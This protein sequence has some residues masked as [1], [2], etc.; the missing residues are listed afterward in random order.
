ML[1]AAVIVV[2]GIWSAARL[3]LDVTPDISNLQVQVLTRVPDLIARR[4]RIVRDP[5]H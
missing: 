4:N 5:A 1:I 2:W 3:S